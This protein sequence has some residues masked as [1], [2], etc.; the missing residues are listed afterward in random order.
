M[1]VKVG[2]N[3][4]TIEDVVNVARY[5]A[6]VELTPAAVARLRKCRA[7]LEKKIT[8]HEIMYGVNTGIGEF[9]EMVLTDEQVKQFQRYLI[10]N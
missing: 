4:L 9:S 2:G 8:A 10:Y 6:K 1:N 5:G 3:S 7:M